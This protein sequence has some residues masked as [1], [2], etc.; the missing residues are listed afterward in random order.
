M[1]NL[2]RAQVFAIEQC[3]SN[4]PTEATYQEICDLLNDDEKNNDEDD[5]PIVT[6]WEPFEG[7]DVIEIMDSMVENLTRL[8]DAKDKE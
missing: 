4:Y 8:L 7:L 1:D 6:V 3:L 2:K 5:C